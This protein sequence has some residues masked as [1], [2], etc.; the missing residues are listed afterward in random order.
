MN[1]ENI[2]KNNNLSFSTIV[3]NQNLSFIA[4]LNQKAATLSNE[5]ED[6][7]K[8][9]GGDPSHLPE[10]F[11]SILND[12]CQDSDKSIFNY[13][14]IAGFD[15]LRTLIA[16]TIVPRYQYKVK[17][18]NILV[19]SGGCS[20]LFLTLKTIL[21]PGDKVL[22]QDPCWEYL[23]RLIE[24][25]GGVPVGMKFFLSPYAQSNWDIF[26]SEVQSHLNNGVK[27]IAINSPLNPSGKIIPTEVINDLNQLCS[28]Y[29]AWLISDDVTTDYNYIE[30]NCTFSVNN[31]SNFI[32]VNSF[33]KN[34]GVTGLRFGFVYGNENLINQIKKSQLYTFMYPNSLIQKL[35]ERYLSYGLDEYYGFIDKITAQYKKNANEYTALLSTIPEVEVQVPEGGLFVFPRLKFGAT[36]DVD[37]LLA[38]HYVAV[39]PGEAFGSQCA[40]HFR[41]FLGVNKLKMEAAVKALKEFLSR[42]NN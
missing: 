35:M 15:T 11:L 34:L 21:N 28:N 10:N 29:D 8:L 1:I 13:S 31:L 16:A 22:I 41:L 33:S 30:K 20:G 24:N 12:V 3:R 36:L 18:D 26:L 4:S 6:V 40:S 7:I 23:P 32:S 25:C 17:K 38:K 9:S 39:A 19:C 5:G 14:P 42:K 37:K 27:V 2:V